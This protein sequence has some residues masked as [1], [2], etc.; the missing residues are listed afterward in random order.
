MTTL[1]VSS[2]MALLA[3]PSRLI[4]N[5]FLVIYV[6]QHKSQPRALKYT[7]LA[8]KN[9]LLTRP[10]YLKIFYYTKKPKVMI[11][12]KKHCK[13]KCRKSSKNKDI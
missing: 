8:F 9:S 10:T 5:I 11:T 2:I 7:N 1:I 3:F 12:N 6:K 13:E 4:N